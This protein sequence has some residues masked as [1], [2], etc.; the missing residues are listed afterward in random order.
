MSVRIFTGDARRWVG[1]VGHVDVVI[2]DPVW[3]NCPPGLLTGWDQPGALLHEALEL[4]PTSVRTVVVVLRTDS[5]P[6]FLQA[7]PERWPF[8]C[9]Q[10][11]SY[12]TQP[13]VGRV[14]ATELAYCFGTF[15]DVA[16]RA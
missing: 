16:F 14:L 7:V 3:P 5:D 9:V 8:V 1:E 4:M 13:H 11:M 12:A 2:T 10:A 6:R 15:R